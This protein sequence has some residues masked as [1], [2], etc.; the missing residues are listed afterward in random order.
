MFSNRLREL[1]LADLELQFRAK[2]WCTMGAVAFATTY[3]PGQADDRLL[4]E[5]F[6]TPLVGDEAACYPALRRVWFESYSAGMVEIKARTVGGS[7][8][9]PRR[10]TPPELAARRAAVKAKLVGMP[11]GGPVG[12]LPMT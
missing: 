1:G 10:L 5:Q 4:V 11:H 9:P 3:S 2:G 8:A 12:C 7:D 6:L